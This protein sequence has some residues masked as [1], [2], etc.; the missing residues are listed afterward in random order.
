MYGAGFE[1]WDFSQACYLTCYIVMLTSFC[2]GL[3]C[4]QSFHGPRNIIWGCCQQFCLFCL[5]ECI[6]FMASGVAHHTLDTYQEMGVPMGRSWFAPNSSWLFFWLLAVV[7]QPMASAT[8]CSTAAAWQGMDQNLIAILKICGLLVALYDVVIMFCYQFVVTSVLQHFWGIVA[9]LLGIALVLKRGCEPVGVPLMA[10]GYI[11][12]ILGYIVV[13]S[14]PRSC[15]NAG[16]LRI[17]CFYPEAFNHNAVY[18]LF[19]AAS[20]VLIYLGTMKQNA[21][22]RDITY[23]ALQ[24]RELE[25]LEEQKY[26]NREGCVDRS[27]QCFSTS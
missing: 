13:L 2:C 8:C 4:W 3:S 20:V 18:H 27:R 19:I 24:M 17:G 16:M 14:A 1:D 7:F 23:N 11:C 22:E 10:G 5:F 21:W 6:G 9:S 26:K 12:R 15:W 25:E